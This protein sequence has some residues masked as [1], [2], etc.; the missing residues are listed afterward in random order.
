MKHLLLVAPAIVIVLNSCPVVSED[1]RVD[2]P[3][4]SLVGMSVEEAIAGRRSVR[5]YSDESLSLEELSQILYAAQGVTGQRGEV[6]LRSAPSAG[7]TYPMEIY[8]FV[9]RVAGLDSGVYRYLPPGHAVELIR[10][11]S[12]GDSLA[13]ACL[14]QS[15]PR[16]AAVSFV[17]AAVPER[18]TASYG[19]RGVRYIYMEAGHIS[20]NICLE[21]TSLGLG[22][23]PIGAFNDVEVDRLIGVDGET[24]FSIYVNS[25][26][27]TVHKRGEGN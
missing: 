27:K 22:A 2:L 25:I 13:A 23:V 6:G 12:Y 1:S 3:E 17:L 9:N 4:P 10:A 15:M 18:T 20:Q 26:G 21:S 24:E 7:A 16:G 8:V 19:S 14:G 11:G 5:S